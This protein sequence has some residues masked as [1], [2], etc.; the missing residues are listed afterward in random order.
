MKL[1]FTARAD[2][3][4]GRLPTPF[5]RRL[6]S[7]CN[8]CSRIFQHPSLHAKKYSESMDVWQG[9]VTKGW[10]FYFKVEGEE[11]VILSII[12]HPK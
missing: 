10:R 1:R 5:A 6:E 4:Y 11:Y 3:D 9:R 2:K 8:F 7:S 12:P